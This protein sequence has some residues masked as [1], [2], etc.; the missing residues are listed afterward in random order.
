MF[1]PNWEFHTWA[2]SRRVLAECQP[3]SLTWPVLVYT[4]VYTFLNNLCKR[5]LIT[6]THGGGAWRRRALKHCQCFAVCL[7]SSSLRARGGASAGDTACT[8]RSALWTTKGIHNLGKNWLLVGLLQSHHSPSVC[9]W[10][11]EV[12]GFAVV[13]FS[14]MYVSL[15]SW[16]CFEHGLSW[17]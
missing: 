2:G 10:P 6:F 11:A 8:T 14:H 3:P 16:G 4:A 17:T 5:P 7:H 13:S 15:W 9:Y 1:S 12:A